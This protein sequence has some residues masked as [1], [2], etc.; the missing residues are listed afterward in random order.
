R[1]SSSNRISKSS[2]PKYYFN[3]TGILSLR[4]LSPKIGLLAENAVYLQL[5]RKS[6]SKEYSDIFYNEINGVEVDFDNRQNE[7]I[8]VKFRDNITK[9][10][11]VKYQSVES[12][13]SFIVKN[14]SEILIDTL[15]MHSKITLDK[16]L[17][18]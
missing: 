5:R 2:V 16:Y 4:S 17:L 10:D 12:K 15:P 13:I 11:I 14:Q 1:K 18:K 3:D 9:E 7:L 8:E 6:F